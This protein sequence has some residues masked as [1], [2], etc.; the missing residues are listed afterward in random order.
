MVITVARTVWIHLLPELQTR[1][2]LEVERYQA[3][4]GFTK[5]V[6]SWHHSGVGCGVW[7]VHTQWQS[8]HIQLS[9]VCL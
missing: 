4:F 5:Q 6:S 7:G 1:Q 8:R 3:L 2:L 9:V